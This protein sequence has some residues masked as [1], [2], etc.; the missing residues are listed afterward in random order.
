MRWISHFLLLAALESYAS[1]RNAVLKSIQCNRDASLHVRSSSSVL[2]TLL[3]NSNR[4]KYGTKVT[5][6]TALHAKKRS[7]DTDNSDEKIEKVTYLNEE[8]LRAFWLK[9]GMSATSYNE[10]MALSKLLLSDNDD[11]DDD[12]DDVDED[13]GI[14][15]EVEEVSSTIGKRRLL[16]GK[17]TESS[18]ASGVASQHDVKRPEVAAVDKK[19]MLKKFMTKKRAES[20]DEKVADAPAP[21]PVNLDSSG[22]PIPAGRSVGELV[23]P[24][25]YFHSPKYFHPFLF[26]GFPSTLCFCM[27]SSYLPT[28]IHSYKTVRLFSLEVLY[29]AFQ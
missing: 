24:L 27:Y 22:V 16:K 9:S 3:S 12:D 23:I 5:S 7:P 25:I 20:S 13:D 10:G 4:I 6:M 8:E 15:K 1:F 29:L 19:K 26:L 21:A 17:K 18:S 11:D 2:I 28:R 14:K